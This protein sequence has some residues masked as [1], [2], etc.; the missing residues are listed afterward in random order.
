MNTD[1]SSELRASPTRI[2]GH[3]RLSVEQKRLAFVACSATDSFLPNPDQWEGKVSALLQV[4]V[5]DLRLVQNQ[6]YNTNYSY[7]SQRAS[8]ALLHQ[9]WCLVLLR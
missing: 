1:T 5:L 3:R 2:Q 8:V 9:R 7:T 6:E 4:F